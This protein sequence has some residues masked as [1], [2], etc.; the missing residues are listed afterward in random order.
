MNLTG[1]RLGSSFSKILSVFPYS[2][3]HGFPGFL[4]LKG[5]F[6]SP[7]YLEIAG[8]SALPLRGFLLMSMSF[9]PEHLQNVANVL[10]GRAAVNLKTLKS[11]ILS[12]YSLQPS[13]ATFQSLPTML[14]C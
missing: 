10:K 11:L 1:P 5:M 14:L 8:M 6:L 4:S 2:Q 13:K 3:K 9:L 12:F 7:Q